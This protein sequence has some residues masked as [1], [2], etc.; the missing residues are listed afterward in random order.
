MAMHGWGADGE[1]AHE[2]A[3]QFITYLLK[4]MVLFYFLALFALQF[5]RH[6][7]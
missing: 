3:G 7:H 1:L 4:G 6:N 5:V 2:D